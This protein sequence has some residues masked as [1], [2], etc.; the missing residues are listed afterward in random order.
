M[1]ALNSLETARSCAAAFDGVLSHVSLLITWLP[2][3]G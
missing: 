3:S 2:F 1:G